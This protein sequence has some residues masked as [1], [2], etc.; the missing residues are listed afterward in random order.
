MSK[1]ILVGLLALVALGYAG[2][3]IALFAMQRQILFQPDTARPDLAAVGLPGLREMRLQVGGVPLLAWWLPPARGGRVVL[4]FHGNGGNLGDRADR[5]RFLAKSGDGVLMPE[6]PGY[7]GNAG[8]PSEAALFA[9]ATAALDFLDAAGVED[10]SIAVYGESLG[11]GVAAFLAAGRR[12]GAV[13]LESP[14]TSIVAIARQRYWFLPVGLLVR[15]RFDTL[16][17]IGR[18]EAPL[19]VAVGERDD[20]VPPAM[21]RAL[22]AAAPAPKQLWVAAEGGHEDLAQFGLLP[23]VARFLDQSM[24]PRSE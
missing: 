7:G 20:I 6:Y 16:D 21:G 14:F 17:R 5:L 22:L 10:R 8:A 15:D 1:R 2:V 12:F 19:L 3:A 13:I 11:T 4:Y 18:L 9:T 23:A 24:P